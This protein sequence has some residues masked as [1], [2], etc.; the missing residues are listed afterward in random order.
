MT[1]SAFAKPYRR[2]VL[3]EPHPAQW[4][5]GT[6]IPRC[7]GRHPAPR[8]KSGLLCGM[9]AWGAV[10][11]ACPP[12]GGG[13]RAGVSAQA[14]DDSTEPAATVLKSR[15]GLHF[16]LPTDWPVEKRNGVVGPIPIEE[17]VSRKFATLEKRLQTLEQQ[18]SVF[19]LRMRVLEEA[20]K[21]DAQ[22]LRSREAA[23]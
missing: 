2:R 9:I 18:V 14:A 5:G 6:R 20:T 13:W 15:D 3:V 8:L 11:L 4:R 10:A 16:Q 7:A 12:L 22:Q 1:P 23:P 17:Y 21:K 19:D